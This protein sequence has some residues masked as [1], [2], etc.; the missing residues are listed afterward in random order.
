MR[1]KYKHKIEGFDQSELQNHNRLAARHREKYQVMLI[2]LRKKG[3]AP[4]VND[5]G[6]EPVGDQE[7]EDIEKREYGFDWESSKT[8]SGE[9]YEAK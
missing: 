9:D 7:M 1:T 2:K 3:R 6:I 5:I 8:L 4:S